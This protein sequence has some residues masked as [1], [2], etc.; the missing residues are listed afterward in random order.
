[1]YI[2]AKLFLVHKYAKLKVPC[3]LSPLHYL[4]S[5]K[6]TEISKRRL[7]YMPHSFAS[8]ELL[9]SCNFYLWECID[10]R[11]YCGIPTYFT[12]LWFSGLILISALWFLL[13]SS[14]AAAR[15]DNFYYPPEWDPSQVWC[16][17]FNWWFFTWFAFIFIIH[18]YLLC[19]VL[20]TS[21]MVNMPWERGQGK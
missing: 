2:I 3:L 17:I 11:I 14:L 19:R 9:S 4:D 15:A 21:F 16:I 5:I 8:S 7:E 13:Q 12:S 10:L 1:V 18:I 20:S 6:R